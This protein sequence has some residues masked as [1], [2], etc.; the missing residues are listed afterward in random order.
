MVNSRRY[1]FTF[2]VFTPTYNRAHTLGR[3]RQSLLSQTFTDFEWLIV[4]DG[5]NDSTPQLVK[6]WQADSPFPIGYIKQANRGKHVAF[7]R[8]VDRAQGE[9]FLTLDSDDTCLPDAL[10]T[11]YNA[12]QDI[13]SS[14]RDEFAAVTGLCVDENGQVIGDSFPDDVLDSNPSE[15]NHRYKIKGEKWGFTRT[16]L[17]KEYPY[18]EPPG[19]LFVPESVVWITIGKKYQTRCVNQPLRVY[20]TASE[21]SLSHSGLKWSQ[22]EGLFIW[23]QTVLNHETDWF[24]RNP[25]S[26]LRSAVNYCRFGMLAGQSLIMQARGIVGSLARLLWLAGLVPGFILASRDRKL[27]GGKLGSLEK[28]P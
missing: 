28:E 19:V 25:L 6:Q 27:L 22:V 2:T 14:A 10:A 9:L 3:V 18:P 16:D 17:L 15:L 1:P 4:D 5:S 13:P 21:D 26:I 24:W 11:L 7:N 12:W 23:H 20:H 8:G